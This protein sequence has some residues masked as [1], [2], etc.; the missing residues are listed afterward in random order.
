MNMEIQKDALNWYKDELELENGDQVRF[1]V[2]YGG[3]SSVQKG[4]SLGVSK[5][6]PQDIGIS[7][8]VEGITFFIEESDIWYFDN[9]DLLVSY[10]EAS[11]EPVFE[12][13]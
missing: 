3:C 11:E 1:F 4:F 6:E 10:S 5:D 13:Q 2:R 12:Y 8:E 9:H 7:T